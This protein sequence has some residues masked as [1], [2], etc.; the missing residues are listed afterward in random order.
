MRLVRGPG[1]IQRG[2]RQPLDHRAVTLAGQPFGDL[3]VFR[4]IDRGIEDAVN[5]GGGHAAVAQHAGGLVGGRQDGQRALVLAAAALP[6][7]RDDA[8]A[9]FLKRLVEAGQKHGL[10]AARLAEDGQHAP[11]VTL[12]WRR[13][14]GL[15]EVDAGGAQGRGDR[16]PGLGLVVGE[17]RG[18]ARHGATLGSAPGNAKP[19]AGGHGK[20]SPGPGAVLDRWLTDV[21][22]R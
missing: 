9:C 2:V 14:R 12:G 4:V 11:R 13:R 5:R 17:D 18:T 21:N 22:L 20:S 10:A 1:A 6:I 3:L 15:H 16:V 8:Q 7:A 19:K